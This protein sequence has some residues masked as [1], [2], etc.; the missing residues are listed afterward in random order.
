MTDIIKL[1]VLIQASA[2]S[3]SA[4]MQPSGSRSEL[5]PS[6]PEGLSRTFPLSTVGD[7]AELRSVYQDRATT[8]P[9]AEHHVLAS[10]LSPDLTEINLQSFGVDLIR[11]EELILAE[12]NLDSKSVK[13]S[14]QTAKIAFLAQAST[15]PNFAILTGQLVNTVGTSSL[16]K[17]AKDLGGEAICAAAGLGPCVSY[18]KTFTHPKTG[19]PVKRFYTI[20]PPQSLPADELRRL[21]ST[22]K[23]GNPRSYGTPGVHEMPLSA[24]T[25]QPKPTKQPVK[26]ILHQN[27]V[28]TIR[29]TPDGKFGALAVLHADKYQ[30]PTIAYIGQVVNGPRDPMAGL[31]TPMLGAELDN[32]VKGGGTL[33]VSEVLHLAAQL[34]FE[35]A[36]LYTDRASL[37]ERLPPNE[38]GETLGT[39][40]DK[41]GQEMGLDVDYHV[42]H[43][44]DST[45]VKKLPHSTAGQVGQDIKKEFH[46]SYSGL[47][48]LRSI[49]A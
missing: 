28:I 13:R 44:V 7:S 8:S 48:R 43:R 22:L 40:Y 26:E 16:T 37:G 14:D 5:N 45:G 30:D 35:Q 2:L 1:G 41:F 29:N 33:A 19:E 47:G 6:A 17:I 3:A 31:N 38:T 24:R 4:F 39:F 32:I 15:V 34:G 9:T 46:Y 25:T 36:N 11:L 42:V 49:E 12:P 23:I 20:Y 10:N 18:E 21:A 27:Y